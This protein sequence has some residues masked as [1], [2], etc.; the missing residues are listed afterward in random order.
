MPHSVEKLKDEPIIVVEIKNP[1]DYQTEPEQMFE[2]IER[3]AKKTEKQGYIIY[4][5]RNFTVTFGDLVAGMQ[6]QSKGTPGSISDP[7]FTSMIIGSDAMLKMATEGFKQD[8]YGKIEVPLYSTMDAAMRHAR[9][10]KSQPSNVN[11]TA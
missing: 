6:A 4:D 8:Q 7:K 3:I 11:P 10:D 1:Y 9:T 2:K 5:C